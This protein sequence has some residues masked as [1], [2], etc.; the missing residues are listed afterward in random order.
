MCQPVASPTFSM[1]FL[2]HLSLPTTSAT[3]RTCHTNNLTQFELAVAELCRKKR[4]NFTNSFCPSWCQLFRWLQIFSR[5]KCR[6]TPETSSASHMEE[7]GPPLTV[8][9]AQEKRENMTLNLSKFD[10][11]DKKMPH[12]ETQRNRSSKALFCITL[13]TEFKSQRHACSA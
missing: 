5:P 6:I 8:H 4:P 10:S 3:L 7:R 13:H 2:G 12:R 11:Y 9:A 1:D